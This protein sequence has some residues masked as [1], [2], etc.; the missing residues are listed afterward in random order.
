MV[1]LYGSADI[2]A[3][4]NVSSVVLG[5]VTS[6]LT[7]AVGVEFRIRSRGADGRITFHQRLVVS[8][9]L[10]ASM[11]FAS[12]YLSGSLHFGFP[13]QHSLSILIVVFLTSWLLR[14]G[15]EHLLFNIGK[16]RAQRIW[17]F[18][19][20]AVAAQYC[21]HGSFVY[22]PMN[23]A[24]QSAN[25]IALL[26]SALLS[27]VAMVSLSG[28]VLRSAEGGRTQAVRCR[29]TYILGVTC[30]NLW[31]AFCLILFVNVGTEPFFR[32]PAWVILEG[33]AYEILINVFSLFI[34]LALLIYAYTLLEK[35]VQ[36]LK[37]DNL[38]LQTQKTNAIALAAE[39][40][41]QLRREQDRI[42]QLERSIEA[43]QKDHQVSIEGLV[44]ALSS[45]EDGMFEWDLEL[46][47]LELS[48]HWRRVLGFENGPDGPVPAQKWRAGILAE[49]QIQLNK[50]MQV[51]LTSPTAGH[52]TQVRYRNSFGNLL[53]LEIRIVAVKNAYGLPS[54]LVGILHDRTDEMDLELSIRAE[55][56]EEALL[57]S[58]KS[59]F[60]D[61]LSHEIRT[62][63][64][65]IGSA[66][67]LIES[68]LRRDRV[69]NYAVMGY[70]DQ[71]GLA[72][73]SLRALVDETLMF[74]GS[75]FSHNN[76]Q[77]KPLDVVRLLGDFMQLQ[78]RLRASEQAFEVEL[79]DELSESE[80]YSDE[81]A[82]SQAVRQLVA[83]AQ[84]K[85]SEIERIV[86]TRSDDKGLSIM[87]RLNT[88]PTWMERCGQTDPVG[89][90]VGIIP[91]KDECLPF[92]LLLTKRV[93]RF[94]GG[95]L[96]IIH[97][98]EENWLSVNLPSLKED[99]CH[100]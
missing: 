58:R 15:W 40:D 74:M 92:S 20:L 79:S 67:A 23:K 84:D 93:I 34:I 46:D 57:S 80:F 28:L 7:L 32:H 39:S 21:I 60:V 59:Q 44:A 45:L 69:D 72:L 61:Y 19:V 49:D 66:K 85:Q 97:R 3:R 70:V 5:F 16:G 38:N 100:V 88:W 1:D 77:V 48:L 27:G 76:L 10:T 87:M 29:I 30:V 89:N 13:V 81:Y 75:G 65:V 24:I 96:M 35:S 22:L 4:L 9:L 94:I 14:Y 26:A 90:A 78:G 73:K 91:F 42:R 2:L 68:C 41:K 54:K 62:P 71:I 52:V 55:L 56:S 17:S 82:F 25:V 51:C 37:R 36:V 53:K 98:C 43:V 47:Q 50:A 64:T 6:L 31:I 18:G 11:Y 99:A 83:F 33:P 63:M 95:R 8:G 12:A 86:M